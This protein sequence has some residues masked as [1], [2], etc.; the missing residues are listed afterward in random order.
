MPRVATQCQHADLSSEHACSFTQEH[1][2][3]LL[4]TVEAKEEAATRLM[5]ERLRAD[6]SNSL[7]LQEQ[8]AQAERLS[9]AD[10]IAEKESELRS[11]LEAQLKAARDAQVKTEEAHRKAMTMLEQQRRVADEAQREAAQATEELRH[12][13]GKIQRSSEREAKSAEAA[14]DA[15]AKLKNLTQERDAME[16]KLK[17]LERNA[18]NSTTASKGENEQLEYYKSMCKCPLCKNSNK[19]A[20]ITKCGHAFCRECIDHRLELRNRKCPGCSQVFDKGYVKDLWL[21]Y[22]ALSLIHI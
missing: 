14:A 2:V 4:K 8:A 9:A 6:R 17:R 3:K 21:E 11:G 22:G 16:R 10:L 15:I 18:G 13:Q 12:E 1:N 19:D 5:Q 7:M 20:I